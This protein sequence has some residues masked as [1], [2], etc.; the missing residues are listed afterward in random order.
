MD[1]ILKPNFNTFNYFILSFV[2]YICMIVG[3]FVKLTYFKE[4]AKRYTDT[5]DAFM[6]ITIVEREPDIVVKAPEKKEEVVK[7]EEPEKK[8]E[9]PKEESKPD[10]TNKPVEPEVIPEVV[11]ESKP[12][13][14]EEPNLKDLFKDI[15]TSKL[16]EDKVVKKKE[17][18]KDQSRIK[19]EKK[20]AKKEAK[21]ASDVINSLQLDKVAKTPK[22]QRTGEYNPYI[23]EITRILE[24]KWTAYKADSNDNALVEITISPN[25]NFSYNIKQL[26]Y[27]SEFN[28]KVRE[29]LQKMTFEI[30]P[31]SLDGK[32]FTIPVKLED[33]LQN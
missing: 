21:A 19:P 8:V 26:S 27:N 33:K 24:T 9:E 5:K 12:A 23:G 28:D 17:T 15:D 31:A 16:K 22:S 7:S 2:L 20:E 18:P 6:D 14:K 29:F 10:T 1:K 32:P 13:E 11:P 4:E 3:I 30:F 25:G